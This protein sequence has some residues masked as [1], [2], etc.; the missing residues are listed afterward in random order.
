MAKNSEFKT[1]GKRMEKMRKAIPYAVAAR[2]EPKL[3]RVLVTLNN[4]LEVAINPEQTQTLQ[5][6]PAAALKAIEISP[7]G[8]ALFFPT[9]DD[10]IYLPGILQGV[11]GTNAWMA[12]NRL[13][14]VPR[15]GHAA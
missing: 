5:G 4:H 14:S 7:S 15:K 1:A 9:L 10:G 6:K 13:S 12:A 8:Y 2:Y 3:H 11:F